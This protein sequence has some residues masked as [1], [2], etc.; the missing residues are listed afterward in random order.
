MPDEHIEAPGEPTILQCTSRTCSRSQPEFPLPSLL[1]R[2]PLYFACQ[3]SQAKP[4]ASHTTSSVM[5][6]HLLMPVCVCTNLDVPVE[7]FPRGLLTFSQQLLHTALVLPP[8]REAALS[9]HMF[10]PPTFDI[11][12]TSILQNHIPPSWLDT[13]AQVRHFQLISFIALKGLSFLPGTFCATFVHLSDDKSSFSPH[14]RWPSTF[15]KPN[16]HC[17][18]LLRSSDFHNPPCAP[19]LQNL[20]HC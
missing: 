17:C 4:S 9:R 14:S 2:Y 20:A 19:H 11:T 18:Y 6:F 5:F 15:P 12:L 13:N 7:V 8:Y 1:S 16:F 3:S 10:V